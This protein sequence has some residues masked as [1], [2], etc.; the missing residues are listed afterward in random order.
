MNGQDPTQSALEHDETRDPSQLVVP[1]IDTATNFNAFLKWRDVYLFAPAITAFGAA[2][3]L[4]IQGYRLTTPPILVSLVAGSVL[5]FAALQI[6]ASSTWY[7]TPRERLANRTAYWRLRWSLP[8]GP[9]ERNTKLHNVKNFEADGSVAGRDGMKRAAVELSG[10]N[11]DYLEDAVQDNLAASLSAGVDDEMSD[12]YW[13]F[14]STTRSAARN[15]MSESRWRRGE[16]PPD[17]TRL[18]ENQRAVERDAAAW[19]ESED[20]DW[21]PSE[22]TT[23]VVVHATEGELGGSAMSAFTSDDDVSGRTVNDLLLERVEAVERAVGGIDGVTTRRVP[24]DELAEASMGY[25]SGVDGGHDLST[26]LMRAFE[27]ESVSGATAAERLL[28]PGFFDVDGTTV[29]VDDTYCRT[30]WMEELPV[31]PKSLF[32]KSLYSMEGVDLDVKWYATPRNTD[33]VLEEL[34]EAYPHVKDEADDLHGEGSDGVTLKSLTAHTEEE[35]VKLA[36]ALLRS[37]QTNAWGKNGYVTVRASSQEQLDAACS[38]VRRSLERFPASSFPI[39]SGTRQ[40]WQFASAAPFSPDVYD[41]ATRSDKTRLALTGAFGALFPNCVPYLYDEGGIRWGRNTLDGTTVVR[42]LLELGSAPHGFTLGKSRSGKTFS[43][44]QA[45]AEWWLDRDDRVLVVLDTQG[46]F[47]GLTNL[48][49]GDHFIVDGDEEFNPMAGASVATMERVFAG[50]IHEQGVDPSDYMATIREGLR[51]GFE[52]AEDKDRDAQIDDVLDVYEDMLENPDEYTFFGNGSEVERRK[53][54]VAKLLEKLSGFRD[55]GKYANFRTQKR[56]NITPETEM[57]Y[58]DC[59]FLRDKGDAEKSVYLM[60]RLMQVAR[61]A[62]ESD[63]ELIFVLDEA[64]VLLQSH[65]V[66]WLQKASREWARHDAALWFVSQSPQEFLKNM[67]GED[68]GAENHRRTLVEQSAFVQ[69][70]RCPRTEEHLLATLGLNE[71][72]I[73]RV[74]DGLTRGWS[75]KGYSECLIS[76]EDVND[77]IELRVEAPPMIHRALVW[78]REEHGDFWEFVRHGP[79]PDE[80]N[81]GD[82]DDAAERRRPSLED[83]QEQYRA[84][85][86]SAEA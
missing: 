14:Y 3:T 35:A 38:K 23:W 78:D 36:Y 24:S 81:T 18:S 6:L 27:R 25:W 44:S 64:H 15:D 72:Q 66:S 19:Q 61:L 26:D 30:F 16:S 79:D 83:V 58:I 7:A 47:K 75:G 8:F 10:R 63:K 12:Q 73:K 68:S 76:F 84:E 69:I 70:F 31:Q 33:I 85:P 48:L 80:L 51:K 29:Q 41:N 62:R 9:D 49:D 40:K 52:R 74:K 11:T 57:A 65:L 34:E 86:T 59:R 21:N 2:A 71:S 67:A 22:F 20:D 42:D 17:E 60:L 5:G 54:Q 46:G 50:V 43:V 13:A 77:W 28:Q 1:P 55:D 32:M 45:V 39:S 37:G 56:G 82:R 53:Q 4:L